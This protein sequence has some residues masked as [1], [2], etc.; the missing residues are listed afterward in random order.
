MKHY[1]FL[2]TV[3][4][5][6][7]CAHAADLPAF[8]GAAGPGSTAS[9]GRGGDVYHVTSLD[10]DARDPQPGTLRHGIKTAPPTG[11]TIVFDVAGV[12]RLQP[13]GRPG[14]LDVPANN[15]TI[16]GQTAPSPGITI[17]G[18]SSKWTGRNVILRHIKFRVGKDQLR[19][20]VATNDGITSYLQDSII[21]HCSVSWYDDEAISCT[22]E[23]RNTTVQFCLMAEGL[24]YKGHSYGCLI[25]SDHDDARISYHH[26][27]FAHNKSRLPRLGSE[28]GTGVIL[29]FSNNIIYDWSG[30]AGYSA[31]D[32]NSRKPLPNRTNFIGNYYIMG[33]SNQPKDV[34]FDG[35]NRETQ[36]Y[37]RNN[38]LDSNRNGKFDGID[39]G[40]DFFK[41][42]YTRAAKPFD[43]DSG[44]IQSPDEALASV[45]ERAGAFWW[46]RD[47][48]DR[49]VIEQVR[50]QTGKMIN[51]IDDIGGFPTITPVHRPPD[52]DTDRD[53]MPD[54]WERK[55]GLDPSRPDN[56]ED[57]DGN[58]YTNLEEYLHEAA[59]DPR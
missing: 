2:F 28:K 42:T 10:D 19:P 7:A 47:E 3:A 44:P 16:A 59:R 8:P 52:Y 35:A 49:R 55:N 12:I 45:L 54:E 18:Q 38:F 20:G 51:E 48:I 25:S 1:L 41:G 39:I 50:T 5:A 56:N 57:H 27:L 4:A 37:S 34:A 26:N 33:P 17:T 36:I 14:W 9:G 31:N 23:A 43:V 46:D 40:W 6:S 24:N 13:P 53:G 21:D 30:R 15:L 11:R 58:G 32:M 22:D 29:N